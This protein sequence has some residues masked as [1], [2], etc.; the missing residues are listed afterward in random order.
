MRLSAAGLRRQRAIAD[1][2]VARD[3]SK[4]YPAQVHRRSVE[5]RLPF[6]KKALYYALMLL[7]TLLVLE[8]MARIAYYAAYG[9]G[10]GGDGGDG[11]NSLLYS[12][13]PTI[14]P[15][16]E[17]A[18]LWSLQ[19]PFYGYTRNLSYHDLNAMPPQQRRENLA[20]IGLLGGSVAQDLKPFLQEALNRWFAANDLPRQ[21]AVIGWA[22]AGQK[23]PQQVIIVANHLLLGGEVDL[24][25]NLDGH[26]ELTGSALLELEDDTFPFFHYYWNN[27][28]SLTAEEVL[29]AGRIQVLRREQARLAAAGQ[30]SPLRWSAVFGLANRWR[31]ESNAAAIIQGNLELA[32][33]EAAYSLEKHGPGNWLAEDELLPEVAR[34]WYR[35]SAALARLAELAGADYYHFLQPSQYAPDSKPL[36]PQELESAYDPAGRHAPFIGPGYPLLR[37]FNP[38]LQRQGINYFDLTGIFADH[39]ETLYRDPCCH[40]NRQGNE[41]LAAAIVRRLEPALRRLGQESPAAPVSALAAARRPPAP[42]KLLLAAPFQ[43]YLSGNGRWLRYG[44]DDCAPADVESRFFLHLTPRDLEDLPPYRREYGYDNRDF[45]FAAA[46]GFFKGGQC[47]AHIRL[48]GYPIAALRTGQYVAGVGEIWSGDFSFS[49]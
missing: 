17:V 40:L 38:A 11:T 42:D 14:P 3:M 15:R 36:S 41:L 26:N 47:Q 22:V 46:G 29:R 19:H 30:V 23:Q 44:R 20:I 10:Y 48:P 39:P 12:P 27:Q 18:E 33:T 5:N 43:V 1:N 24:I 2:K 25:I 31:R 37:Q 45:S 13:A 16:R 34:G 4:R 7:L 32:A 21:P 28:V 9:Q 8:G 35:G 6:R 49:E